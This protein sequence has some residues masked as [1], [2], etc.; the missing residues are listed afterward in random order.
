MR[1]HNAFCQLT[2]VWA[3]AL[4]SGTRRPGN[5]SLIEPSALSDQTEPSALKIA[6]L[7]ADC[8]MAVI[9]MPGLPTRIGPDQE[10]AIVGSFWQVRSCAPAAEAATSC[11]PIVSRKL[12]R[13][14]VGST[15]AA[16]T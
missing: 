3:F 10:P 12:G 13:K 9:G 5:S 16:Q 4:S 15:H 2:A 11:G 7:L 14:P 8:L 1:N 6:S